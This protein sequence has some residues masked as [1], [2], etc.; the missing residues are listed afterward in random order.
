[1]SEGLVRYRRIVL[2]S[3]TS[4][5]VRGI[6]IV[7][8]LLSV[9]LVLNYLGEERY[10]LFVTVQSIVTLTYIL[11]LGMGNVVINAVTSAATSDEAKPRLRTVIASTFFTQ[12]AA[13]GLVLALF[14]AV[15]PWL[16]L[17]SF[18]GVKEAATRDEARNATVV[19]CVLLSFALPVSLVTRIQTGYQETYWVALGTGVA[20][21][22]SLAAQFACVKL[23]GTL[24]SFVA[25]TT[26]A[27]IL[28]QIGTWV[29]V[30]ARRPWVIPVLSQ[31]ERGQVRTI[32]RDSAGFLVM[33]IATLFA[34][35]ADNFVLTRMLDPVAVTHYA[36]PN[37]LFSAI[38]VFVNI[39]INPFWPAFGDAQARGE[40]AWI[41]AALLRGFV[42]AFALSGGAC[43]LVFLLFDQI[44]GLWLHDAFVADHGVVAALALWTTLGSSLYI[45][46]IYLASVGKM[47]APAVVAVIMSAL[48][49]VLKIVLVRK[50][51]VA[52]VVWATIIACVLVTLPGHALL[53]R[54]ALNKVFA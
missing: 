36:V 44:I 49:L 14:L 10:G 50:I 3:G 37:R 42:V 54:R 26:L 32:L 13:C 15:M 51:G 35:T 20:N 48:A 6:S 21:V 16:D 22:L 53:V 12:A 19:F 46:N 40:F 31:F 11:D 18:Y 2:S 34:F 43:F 29:L 9:P 30:G 33:Q 23:H 39:A 27:P 28:V 7:T 25:V 47:T 17:A 45:F 8:T 38:T 5:A 52:G 4:I 1:M 24:T 41:K